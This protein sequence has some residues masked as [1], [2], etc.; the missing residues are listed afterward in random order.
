[1][2][3]PYS[4]CIPKSRLPVEKRSLITRNAASIR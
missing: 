1:L 4:F 3:A 2:V